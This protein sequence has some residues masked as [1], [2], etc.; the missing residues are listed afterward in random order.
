MSVDISQFHQVFFEESFEGLDVMEDSLMSLQPDDIDSEVIN[1]IFRAAHSIKGGSATFGFQVVAD[2]T[3]VLETLLDEVRDGKRGISQDDIDLYLK[4]GDCLR[5]MLQALQ[6]GVDVDTTE[7]DQLKATFQAILDGGEAP[8]SVETP[9]VA[10]STPQT[11]APASSPT[12]PPAAAASSGKWEISFKSDKEILRTGN[13]P[14]RMFRELQELGE[15]TVEADQSELLSFGNMEPEACYLH[16]HM[17]LVS[18]DVTEEQ[19]KEVF[20]WVEDECEIKISQSSSTGSGSQIENGTVAGWTIYF[21]PDSDILAT[22][23]EPFRMFRELA[24][25]GEYTCEAKLDLMPDF[26]GMEP[27]KCHLSWDITVTG[28]EITEEQVIEVFEWVDDQAKIEVTPLISEAASGEPKEASPRV[29]PETV[30]EKEAPETVAADETAKKVEESKPEPEVSAPTASSNQPNGQTAAKKPAARNNQESSS[31]RVGIDKVDTLINMVGELVITQS[32]L[33]QIGSDFSEDKLPQLLQGLSQLEHNTRELQESVMRI[34]M[35]PIS[36]SFNRFPRLV[37]DLGRQ[38][39][40]DIQLV[41]QGESTE[42]DKTV[43]E[44]IGDPLVHLVRNS[45][46]HG[47]ELPEERTAAGKPA[48]GT[49]TLNA[50][51]KGGNVIIEVIDDGK[52]LDR[53]RILSKAIENG[54]VT[55]SQAELL[56][57]DQVYDMIFQ[58][59]FST[60]QVVSDVSGRGV[61]M[62]VVRRNIQELNGHV[63]IHSTPGQ[64]SIT[65]IRLPLTLAIL[66]GQLIR[67][68]DEIY[69]CPLVSIIESLQMDRE[70]INQVAGGANL[71]RLREE[72]IPI[73]SLHQVFEVEADESNNEDRLLVVVEADGEKVGMLVDELLAQQ[74]VVIKSLEQNYQR[75]EGVSGA[76]ILGDGKVALILDIPGI[77]Q[78]AG[79]QQNEDQRARLQLSA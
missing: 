63:E 77:V 9:A 73:I 12:V 14:Y 52:G 71:Y 32:M 66:D 68:N 51:H 19:I 2:F 61:G 62:D 21:A 31:I 17:T 43:M 67:L 11:E 72:Y 76:T 50:Y 75:V 53:S 44:K 25:L 29:A 15:L 18:E 6:D 64:G 74:Q 70:R 47:L 34:R 54:L 1:A 40:K 39:G 65:R 42:L 36:F 38:L 69:I 20:E 3:H 37:R 23:N 48:Q 58:P 28:E 60:A 22:G 16:W 49:V 57:D 7:S 33:G 45:I 5:A 13:E 8:S 41:M 35:L 26:F 55:E 10:T 78:L 30:A 27:E 59:G 4:A 56:S 46:D 24:E 79:T